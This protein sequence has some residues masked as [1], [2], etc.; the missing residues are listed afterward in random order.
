MEIWKRTYLCAGLTKDEFDKYF[1]DHEYAYA[2]QISELHIFEKPIDPLVMWP[3]FKAP[4]SFCYIERID[5]YEEFCGL[6]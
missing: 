5:L 3:Q 2:L 1:L 4:Q 6:V